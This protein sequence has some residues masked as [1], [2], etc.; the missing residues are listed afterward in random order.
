MR[1]TLILIGM[2]VLSACTPTV[3]SGR[4][5]ILCGLPVPTFTQ[6]ELEGL[7]DRSLSELDNYLA[8]KKAVCNG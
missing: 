1:L 5:E 6:E 3:L 7:S 8:K 4:T 2:L